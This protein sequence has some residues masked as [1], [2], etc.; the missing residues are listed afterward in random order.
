[1]KQRER[2]KKSPIFDSVELL[3]RLNKAASEALSDKNK[4]L[5]SLFSG[6]FVLVFSQLFI[7]HIILNCNYKC[8]N[9]CFKM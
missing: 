9:F 1:M 3:E 2:D 6:E 5:E 7:Y 8:R 4:K